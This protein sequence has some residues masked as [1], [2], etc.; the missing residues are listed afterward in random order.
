MDTDVIFSSFIKYFILRKCYST[1]RCYPQYILRI[2]EKA[3]VNLELT[4]NSEYVMKTT[5]QLVYNCRFHC[6]P[7]YISRILWKS[8]NSIQNKRMPEA[9]QNSTDLQF[10]LHSDNVITSYV[11]FTY[12]TF[13]SCWAADFLLSASLVRTIC[14]LEVIF[15]QSISWH[16]IQFD[17]LIYTQ[18]NAILIIRFC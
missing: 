13:E 17:L 5:I 3:F 12:S 10:T 9:S 18:E 11:Y 16:F 6:C 7:H 4:K 2:L 8:E 1:L 15:G 14:Q